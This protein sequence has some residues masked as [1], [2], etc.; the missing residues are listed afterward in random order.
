MTIRAATILAILPLGSGCSDSG[1]QP[2]IDAGAGDGPALQIPSPPLR[3][4]HDR[5]YEHQI[6]VDTHGEETVWVAAPIRPAWLD[7]DSATATLS[8]T[9]AWGDLGPHTLRLQATTASSS[10]A[11][12]FTILVEKSEVDCRQSFGD[13]AASP[14]V[15]PFPPGHGYEINQGY[16]PANPA[17]GHHR[18]LAYDFRMPI[19]D[20]VVAS[21]A[22]RVLFVQE[23]FSDGTRV[24]GQE[25]FV[26]IRHG[27]G[28]VMQYVHLTTNGALVAPGAQVAQG[29]PIGLSGD[30]GC[31]SGPHLHVALF[32]DGTDFSR[33]ATLPVNYRNATGPLDERGGLV[34]GGRY[35]AAGGPGSPGG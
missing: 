2:P 26:F 22:G 5:P 21:R 19:G 16:C 23:G 4:L 20:T 10:S 29:Q 27:D 31:S 6:R 9:P 13:P 7:F 28:T 24:C 32:R 35:V 3:A 1:T 25:N 30:S 12:S 14:F 11:R 33:Q 34:Q 15:L 8:G 18:W 17:W